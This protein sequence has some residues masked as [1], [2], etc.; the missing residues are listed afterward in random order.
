[1]GRL[2]LQPRFRGVPQM[3]F[4][5]LRSITAG[6]LPPPLRLQYGLRWGRAER[7]L[8]AVCRKVFPALLVLMPPAIRFLPPARHAY[9]RAGRS[10]LAS[11]RAFRTG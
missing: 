10:R 2:V 11:N 3:A 7:A 5:P 6:L 4:S 9:A 1:M 8:F